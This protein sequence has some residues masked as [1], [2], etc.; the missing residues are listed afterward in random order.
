[1]AMFNE[2]TVHLNKKKKINKLDVKVLFTK[3]AVERCSRH[4]SSDLFLRRG[5]SDS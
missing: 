1:M 5:T 2:K 3:I 4:F